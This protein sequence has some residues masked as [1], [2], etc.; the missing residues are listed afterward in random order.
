M[1]IRPYDPGHLEATARLWR[2]STVSSGVVAEDAVSLADLVERLPVEIAAGW[3]AFLGWRGET[4]VGFLALKPD[5]AC[6]SQLFVLPEAQGRGVGAAMLDF[7]KERLPDGMW[8]RTSADNYGARR[9]YERHGFR[10]TETGLHPRAGYPTVTY[11]W[12]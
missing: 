7:A 1:I 8:L 4:M 5:E 12:P 11:R 2:A 3:A 6:L 9:F 10:L